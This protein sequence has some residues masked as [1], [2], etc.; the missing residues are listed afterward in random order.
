MYNGKKLETLLRLSVSLI[1]QSWHLRIGV[2]RPI[3]NHYHLMHHHIWELQ[4]GH[5]VWVHGVTF[6][7]FVVILPPTPVH[8]AVH[9]SAA[10][11][12]KLC[13]MTLAVRSFWHR[14]SSSSFVGRWYHSHVPLFQKSLRCGLVDRAL[15]QAHFLLNMGTSC[16]SALKLLRYVGLIWWV[17]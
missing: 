11:V 4:W 12:A 7:V 16:V 9:V 15:P 10:L 3:W 6:V 13:T 17:S 8:D 5:L 1:I 2:H 14:M